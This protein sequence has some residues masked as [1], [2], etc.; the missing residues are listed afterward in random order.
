MDI[1]EIIRRVEIAPPAD[2]AIPVETPATEEPVG[3]P[4]PA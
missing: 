3:E 2:P 4:V 1:G